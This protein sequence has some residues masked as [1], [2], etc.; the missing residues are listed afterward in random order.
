[1]RDESSDGSSE[2]DIGESELLGP[3]EAYG[4]DA[5]TGVWIT[6]DTRPEDLDPYADPP[7]RYY[8]LDEPDD[9]TVEEFNRSL[10]EEIADLAEAQS[11]EQAA[12]P[13]V[14]GPPAAEALRG[15][16][17]I[18]IIS[19]P[20]QH[21]SAVPALL[22]GLARSQG[23]TVT[24]AA[25][26]TLL[27]LVPRAGN[28]YLSQFGAAAL[29]IADPVA[30]A[31]FDAVPGRRPVSDQSKRWPF[32]QHQDPAVNE[33]AWLDD[34]VAAQREAGANVLLS[35]G[36][37]LPG[38]APDAELDAALRHLDAVRNRAEDEP[39]L[40]NLM[41]ATGWLMY[42]DRVDDVAERV[43]ESRPDALWLTT[44]WPTTAT[45][46][47]P[48]EQQLLAGY[49]DLCQALA[50]EQIPVLLPTTD[51]TGWWCLAHGAAGFGTGLSAA[52]RGFTPNMRGGGTTA[53]PKPR[54]F[55]PEL[56]HTI[57]R[58]EHEALTAGGLVAQCDC[59]Y[60]EA[61]RNTHDWDAH[62]QGAHH[63]CRLAELTAGVANASDRRTHITELVSDALITAA[64]AVSQVAMETA[65]KPGH[66]R[67][68]H[69]LLA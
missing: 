13:D 45:A 39:S 17:P 3:P 43:I 12:T 8:D 62:T 51:L 2:S 37:F 53:P 49:R 58:T 36:R 24:F 57:L 30:H 4:F 14:T 52:A 47:Q 42:P 15:N 23:R 29:R 41:L 66:L 32:Q 7:S 65:S 18:M 48:V 26:G 50:D 44:L 25:A 40:L 28:A 33:A 56:L 16:S 64:S 60:C 27:Q 55:T 69:Q 31:V 1:M 67:V 6:E 10:A 9:D 22:R 34:V 59:P 20:H 21:Y 46:S 19:R 61:S 68:W 5:L 11:A 54:I 38:V 63:L 35:P